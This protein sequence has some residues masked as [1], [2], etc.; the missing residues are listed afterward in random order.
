MVECD[1]QLVIAVYLAV[2]TEY[3]AGISFICEV[4]DTVRGRTWCE[5]N[6]TCTTLRK[7]VIHND[8]TEV[9]EERR[10]G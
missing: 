5:Y 8:H 4:T 9:N 2:Q 7:E 3:G 1:G 10:V 6:K